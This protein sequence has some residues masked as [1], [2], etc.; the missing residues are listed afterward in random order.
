M[1][2]STQVDL[3]SPVSDSVYCT[4]ME[5]VRPFKVPMTP[6]NGALTVSDQR[7]LRIIFES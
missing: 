5:E 1:S 7:C 4:P 6:E 3:L 2:K